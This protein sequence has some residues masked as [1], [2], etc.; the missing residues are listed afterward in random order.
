[1]YPGHCGAG[2]GAKG[3]I[4]EGEVHCGGD[5]DTVEEGDGGE[6]GQVELVCRRCGL[7]GGL[8]QLVHAPRVFA[9]AVVPHCHG[10]T[11]RGNE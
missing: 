7:Q 5:T 11:Q 4:Y 8:H 9:Q 10:D 1:M 2:A 3:A 6:E